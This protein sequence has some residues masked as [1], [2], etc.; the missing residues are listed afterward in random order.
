MLAGVSSQCAPTG[1]L[2]VRLID[3][4]ANKQKHHTTQNRST[5]Q[6]KFGGFLFDIIGLRKFL[7]LTP[8][9][10]YCVKPV[11]EF[12]VF[13]QQTAT[14]AENSLGVLLG[15]T[16]RRARMPETLIVLLLAC[17]ERASPRELADCNTSYFRCLKHLA[18][19]DVCARMCPLPKHS[20]LTA[21]EV[22]VTALQVLFLQRSPAHR[23][24][25]AH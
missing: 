1:R 9:K 20:P 5:L 25:A 6:A 23:S 12:T 7:R 10:V 17:C 22:V 16:Q 2:C 18:E 19:D 11:N 24:W 21:V 13:S 4:K 3:P 14:K 15:R 8:K